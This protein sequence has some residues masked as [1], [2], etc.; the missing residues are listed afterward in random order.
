M[1]KSTYNI[2][3]WWGN[4]NHNGNAKILIFQSLS[5]L[6]RQISN[7]CCAVVQR[8]WLLLILLQTALYRQ[9]PPLNQRIEA[10][11]AGIPDAVGWRLRSLSVG[12][13]FAIIHWTL[14]SVQ[15]NTGSKNQ[16]GRVKLSSWKPQEI[17]V[18]HFILNHRLLL[19]WT[20]KNFPEAVCLCLA[21]LLQCQ[22]GILE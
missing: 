11:A 21:A 1:R 20:S 13:A 15:L 22:L 12:Y 4:H 9:L 19:C 16:T 18:S 2:W 6:Q 14:F 5:S 7:W 8:K 3:T 17:A 10:I